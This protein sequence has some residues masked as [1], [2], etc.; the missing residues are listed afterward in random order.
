[1]NKKIHD[2]AVFIEFI[3]GS[4][5][6]I[7]FHLVLHNEEAA[8]I[9]FGVGSLLSLATYLLRE[10]IVQARNKVLD[11]YNYAHE[12]TFALA[13][14]TDPECKA[15]AHEI[16]AGTKNVL[17]LL[18]QGYI[19][20]D[21]TEFYMKAAT[22]M[23][24]CRRRVKAVNPGTAGWNSRGALI[25]YYQSNLRALARGVRITRIFVLNRGGLADPTVQKALLPQIRDGI[26]VR[27]AYR[28]ELPTASD[29]R[30][31]SAT[32]SLEFAIFDDRVAVAAFSHPGA[33]FGRKTSDPVQVANHKSL[34][35]LIEHHSQAVA[36]EG[37][38][39][40]LAT[41]HQLLAS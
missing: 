38:C 10:D 23:D 6:A 2:M 29:M 39:I 14:M 17:G 11:K 8:Y 4:G 32:S 13:S 30:G 41:N 37:D 9:I 25:N 5:L 16:L 35:D 18:Q 24:E 19:P 1:M 7:F 21:E 40:V 31:R 36:A 34:Y 33:Y 27:I 3:S 26:E 15:K 12:I 22:Y 20:F 28:D